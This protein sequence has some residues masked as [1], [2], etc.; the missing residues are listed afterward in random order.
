MLR[1]VDKTILTIHLIPNAKKNQFIE[2]GDDGSVKLKLSAQPIENK[3]NEALIV[4][5]AKEL[6]LKKSQIELIKGHKSR[7]KQVLF[8]GVSK[9]V[10]LQL[11]KDLI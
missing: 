7:T 4:F 6:S 8:R 5:L 1:S 10:L 2:I 11:I 3:A 9:Q